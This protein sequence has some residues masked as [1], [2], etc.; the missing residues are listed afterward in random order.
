M[1]GKFEIETFHEM[2]SFVLDKLSI[3]ASA[4]TVTFDEGPNPLVA[5]SEKMI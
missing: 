5:H 4:V 1:L 3:Y 2:L